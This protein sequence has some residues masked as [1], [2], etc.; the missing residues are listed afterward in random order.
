MSQPPP[1]VRPAAGRY[2][3]SVN[4]LVSSLLVCLLVVGSF[5]ALR[6]C[7]RDDLEVRPEAV[8]YLGT[9]QDLQASGARP[10]YPDRL[11]AG[12]RVTSLDVVPGPHVAWGLGMLTDSG[13]FAGLRQED[14]ALERLLET[15]V[16]DDPTEGQALTVPGDLASRWRTFT[17]S[18]GDHAYAAQI[19]ED[20]V[21]VYGS[22]TPE[23][24]RTLLD[25]LTTTVR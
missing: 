15:Y 7:G 10:V 22:A 20:W 12:W 2:P 19:G 16:D 23:E 6:A 24:L 3:R 21:L 25:L 18:G 14:A 1:A 4:G 8:D 17:D 5:V 9:V 13:R 11:P